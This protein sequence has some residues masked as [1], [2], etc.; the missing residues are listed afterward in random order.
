ML[1]TFWISITSAAP[2]HAQQAVVKKLGGSGR[3][4]GQAFLAHSAGRCLAILPTHVVKEAGAPVNLRREG[5]DDVLGEVESPVDLGDDLSV[6]EVSGA[7]TR[8][9]GYGLATISRSV[10]RRV[11]NGGLAMLRTIGAAGGIRQVSV[12]VIDDGGEGVLMIQPTHSRDQLMKGYSGSM[13]FVGDAPVGMLLSVR[14]GYGRVLR[15][16]VALAAVEAHLRGGDE[17]APRIAERP[18]TEPTGAAVPDRDGRVTGWSALPIDSEHRA[19][20]L[21]ST[22]DA[23]PWIADVAEWPV[24]L[25]IDLPEDRIVVSGIVLEAGAVDDP[26][27]L[28]LQVESFL[29][30]RE[31]KPRWRSM[32]GG[33]AHY[34]D[35]RA[36]FTFAPTWARNIKLRFS[37]VRDGGGRIALGRVR[38]ER[39]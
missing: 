18:A 1:L 35:G 19:V 3:E 9:C 17:P 25:E 27:Q 36:H 23:P 26:A 38:I 5:R 2:S 29:N 33:T 30:G 31:G 37:N 28:P 34:E 15:I 39:P 22:A 8:Q 12:T 13:L 20:N 21:V 7:L 4:T 14:K 11:R 16:D 6:G 10:E 32:A 24:E